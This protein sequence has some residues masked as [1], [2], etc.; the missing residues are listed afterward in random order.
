MRKILLLALL[1]PLVSCEKDG[2]ILQLAESRRGVKE[3]IKSDTIYIA[4]TSAIKVYFNSELYAEPSKLPDNLYRFI[5]EDIK[6]DDTRVYVVKN[7]TK[8][9]TVSYKK[10][11]GKGSI[12][13]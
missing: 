8:S 9:I 6:D 1:L 11:S 3:G 7:N 12:V 4:S 10:G 5:A 2:E 13:R